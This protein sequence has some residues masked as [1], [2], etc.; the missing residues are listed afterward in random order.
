MNGILSKSLFLRI[1]SAIILVPLVLFIV[2]QGGVLFL[3]ALALLVAISVYEW[4][5]L[6]RGA[7]RLFCFG[8]VGCVYVLASFYAAYL[9][10]DQFGFAVSATFLAALW[11]SDI[12][13]YISG[14]LVG[15]AKM[16]ETI[17][18][19]KTWAGFVGGIV[20]TVLTTMICVMSIRVLDGLGLPLYAWAGV[21]VVIAVSGQVGDLIVSMLKRRAHAKDTGALIPG[22]GGLLDRIDSLLLAAPVFLLCLWGLS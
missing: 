6:A 5:V 17:S 3:C 22:H 9:I 8:A 4:A 16:A 12:G 10:R 7:G 11:A 20:F 14:K 2:W 18:P 13:A 19:N 1:V 15:G 21:A